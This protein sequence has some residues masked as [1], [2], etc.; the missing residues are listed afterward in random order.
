MDYYQILHVGRT[1]KQEEIKSAYRKLS[2]KYHP[3]NAGEQAREQ[4]EKVQ[5]AY[6]VL[7]EEEKRAAYDRKLESHAMGGNQKEWRTETRRQGYQGETNNKGPV[8]GPFDTDKLF[9]GF[10]RVKK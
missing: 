1:A 5:E 3:D 8:A 7:G 2:R 9:E 10:F 6:A 4:F